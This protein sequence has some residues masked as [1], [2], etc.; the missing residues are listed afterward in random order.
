MYIPLYA[1]NNYQSVKQCA[2]LNEHVNL[3]FP[4]YANNDYQ[5]VKQYAKLNEHVD[6]LRVSHCLQ[7]VTLKQ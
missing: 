7:T 2:K 5:S 1:N 4:L 3:S 6:L